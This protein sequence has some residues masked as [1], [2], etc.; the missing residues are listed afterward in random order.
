MILEDLY[1][2]LRS[3]HVQAQGIVD[4]LTQPLVVLDQNFCVINAS[5][6]FIHT[7][8]VERDA[9]L[10]NSLFSLGN[11]E[12]DIPD[13]RRLIADIIPK[14]ASVAGYEVT[15]DFPTLGRRTFLVDARR[16]VHPDNNSTSILVLFDDVTESN[17]QE[18]ERNLILSET[19][20]RMK[21]LLSVVRAIAMQTETE[22]RTAEEYRGVFLGRL[23]AALRAQELAPSRENTDFAALLESAV[24]VAG[25]ERVRLEAGPAVELPS[26]RVLP[27]SMI[28][29]ELATNALKY[30]ALSVPQGDVRVSWRMAASKG[31]RDMLV[32]EWREENGP[33]LRPPSRRGYGTELIVGT[34]RHLGGSAELKFDA[35]GLTAIV[36]LPIQD[37]HD[38]RRP[39]S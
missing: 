36:N 19:R 11:G 8:G 17:R 21:N 34:A 16:L 33:P 25:A 30:G 1:R 7:F 18:M 39:P 6:A 22:E 26:S 3:G 24:I 32:C 28:F 37:R 5:N 27:V 13:L 14:A 12:W 23:D 31:E 4:T 10:G 29:H 20:H 2:L 9:V 38:A 35:S 15:H